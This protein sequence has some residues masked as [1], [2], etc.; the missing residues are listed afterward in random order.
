MRARPQLRSAIGAIELHALEKLSSEE[1]EQLDQILQQRVP[2]L[3]KLTSAH[4]ATAPAS[5]AYVP[6]SHADEPASFAST[7]VTQQD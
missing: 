1:L 2:E 3:R 7:R 4:A 5:A 6:P